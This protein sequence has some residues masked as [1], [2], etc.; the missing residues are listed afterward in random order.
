HCEI[1]TLTTMEPDSIVPVSWGVP[2][3]L[4][5]MVFAQPT[6]ALA[7]ARAVLAGRPE[8]G[9]AS[10]AHQVIGLVHREFG[11]LAAAIPHLR[12]ALTLARRAGSAHRGADLRASLG[13]ALVHAGHTAAGLRTL[14][15][16]AGTVGGVSAARV[17][18]RLGGALRVLGRH[19]E[20]LAELRAAIPV[21]REGQD[22]VW[23]GRALSLRALIQL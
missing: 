1:P 7:G 16:A 2:A 11:E 20:A 10:I 4:L 8:P 19:D 3:D 14:R 9:D 6:A 12:R 13:I 23:L 5:P 15:E 22:T 18:F 21:L 17:R